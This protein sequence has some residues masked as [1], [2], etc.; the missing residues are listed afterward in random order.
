M[1]QVKFHHT[2]GDLVKDF[3]VSASGFRPAARKA[4]E[5]TARSGWRD[6]RRIARRRSGPHGR[7]YWRR[8]GLERTGGLEYEFGPDGVPKTEFVGAGWRNSGGNMDLAQA[9]DPLSSDLARRL[10]AAID[11]SWKVS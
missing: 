5:A 2:L 9:S 7:F 10:R 8:I 3:N 1:A 4:V 11:A 6:A